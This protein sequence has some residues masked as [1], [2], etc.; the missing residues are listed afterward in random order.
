M[1]THKKTVTVGELYGDEVEI[2]SGLTVGDK[3]IISGISKPV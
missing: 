1:T 2:L 3:L